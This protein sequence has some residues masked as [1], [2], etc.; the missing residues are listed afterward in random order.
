MKERSVH[1]Y[2]ALPA[3]HQAAKIAQPGTRPLHLPPALIAPQFSPVLHGRLRAVLAMRTHQIDASSGHALAQ[4]VRITRLVVDEPFGALPR[5]SAP[6]T[7]HRHRLQRR[8]PQRHFGRGRRVQEVSHRHTVAVDHHHPLRAFAPLSFADTRPP[9]FAGAKL[10]SAQAADQSSW[11]RASS[12]PS[13]ARQAFSHT[14]WASQ[15]RKRLQQV[16]GEGYC[17]GRSFQRAPVRKIHRIPATQGRLGRGVGPP[18][19]EA[20]G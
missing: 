20:W 16:L 10:P 14:S 3:H 2:M 8:L 9:F 6:L 15:A 13:N 18:Q 11:P 7:R 4:C 19:G 17:L 1:R 5:P 12:W